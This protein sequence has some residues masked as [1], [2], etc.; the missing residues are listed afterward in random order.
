MHFGVIAPSNEMLTDSG[1]IPDYGLLV[2]AHNWNP[3]WKR[4]EQGHVAG[5]G[6]AGSG[7]AAAVS[8]AGRTAVEAIGIGVATGVAVWL[9]TRILD[10]IFKLERRHA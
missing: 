1:R 8:A 3:Y 2:K 10:R 5:F 6:D 7:A 9:T 4:I